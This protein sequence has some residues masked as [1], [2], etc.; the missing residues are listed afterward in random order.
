MPPG[1]MAS[2]IFIAH[3]R[4]VPNRI[5]PLSCCDITKTNTRGSNRIHAQFV[6]NNSAQITRKRIM[7]Y[8]IS[9]HTSA[10]SGRSMAVNIGPMPPIWSSAII[11]GA[12][13]HAN[14][15]LSSAPRPIIPHTWVKCEHL[16]EKQINEPISNNRECSQSGNQ[17]SPTH[18]NNHS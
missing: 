13:R 6:A 10:F 11:S 15:S 14:G 3:G 5:R 12:T 17:Y 1:I 16:I 8:D 2:R 7:R 18:L 4:V 9:S